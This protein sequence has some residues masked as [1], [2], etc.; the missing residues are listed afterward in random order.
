[1]E[2]TMDKKQLTNRTNFV[3]YILIVI[4][5]VA[6][7]NFL[8]SK[9][10]VRADLTA[11]KMYTISDATKKILR[12]VDDMV[13]IKVFISEKNLPPLAVNM[14]RTIKDMLSEYQAYSRGNVQVEYFDPTDDQEA[15]NEA[16]SLG[17]QEVPMQI[18]QK[19]KQENVMCFMGLALL[20]GDKKE[21]IP[22]LNN[23][24]N[25][26]YDLTS[27]ILKATRK[28]VKKVAFYFGNGPHMFMPEQYQ[29]QQ[30]RGQTPSYNQLR[31]ALQEQFEVRDAGNL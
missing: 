4:G 20:Y 5:F 24:G 27:R 29:Q 7:A 9:F 22:I 13:T 23:V 17:L 18:I 19:D 10:F 30:Q 21:N 1:M 11:A 12:N 15:K 26:E 25:L 14:T 3:L 16:R 31:D 8:L 2:I 28:E 6:V